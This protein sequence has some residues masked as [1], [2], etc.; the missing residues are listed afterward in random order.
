MFCFI[1][2]TIEFIVSLSSGIAT[3][4][5]PET[6]STCFEF[7]CF[8]KPPFGLQILLHIL[9]GQTIRPSISFNA[10]INSFSTYRTS[11]STISIAIFMWK[12]TSSN[13][14]VSSRCLTMGQTALHSTLFL[15]FLPKLPQKFPP[16][17]FQPFKNTFFI[18]FL[19]NALI[20]LST[21]L[22]GMHT[23]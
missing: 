5:V 6:S 12:A 9:Q 21:S 8:V 17:Q 14:I 11:F 4:V 22:E 10:S 2:L 15:P 1:V 20:I 13:N 19:L 16:F 7:L 3:L 18:R 23:I